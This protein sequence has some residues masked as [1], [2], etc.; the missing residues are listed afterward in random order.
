[1]VWIPGLGAMGAL[2]PSARW[3][4]EHT[5]CHLLDVPGFAAPAERAPTPPLVGP[6]AEEGRDDQTGAGRCD[7]QVG[8]AAS[9][10]EKAAE[11]G[12]S[13]GTGQE[14]MTSKLPER[15]S[16]AGQG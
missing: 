8:P 3:C 9:D 16:G 2:L 13:A 10:C 7:Q 6:L 4:A 14:P 1:M 11:A 5:A 12:T 15:L